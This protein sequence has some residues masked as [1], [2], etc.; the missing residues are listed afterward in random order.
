MS[1]SH[2]LRVELFAD[3][4]PQ[5]FAYLGEVTGRAR[6]RRIRLLL[7]AGHSVLNGQ[8]VPVQPAPASPAPTAAPADSVPARQGSVLDALDALGLDPAQFSFPTTA[9]VTP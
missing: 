3:E 6:A 1:K 9:A 7:R 5:L 2:E 8:T 4:D